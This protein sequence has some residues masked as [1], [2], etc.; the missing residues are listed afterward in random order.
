MG[1]ASVSDPPARHPLRCCLLGATPHRLD[2]CNPG[3]GR[4]YPLEPQT[5]EKSLLLAS[6]LDQRGIRQTQCH[7]ALLSPSLSLFSSPAPSSRWLVHSGSTGRSDLHSY[8]HCCFS[9]TTGGAS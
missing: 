7:R 9:C 2:S 1:C 8:Y 4:S 3:R 6:H 5:P